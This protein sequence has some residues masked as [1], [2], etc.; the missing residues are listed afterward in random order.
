MMIE[1]DHIIGVVLAGGQSSRMGD[2]DKAALPFGDQ[3]MVLHAMQRLARQLDVISI[4]TNSKILAD[5]V[6]PAP[7]FADEIQDFSG[8]LAGIAAAM[9]FARAHAKTHIVTVATDTP[10]F[11]DNLVSRLCQS[12][13]SMDDIVLA[14][15]NGFRHPVFGLWPAHHAKDLTSWLQ[16]SDT[17]KVM[18]WVKTKPNREVQFDL[19]PDGFD[20]FFNVNTPQELLTAKRR[21]ETE[22]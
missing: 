7:V 16:T 4:N 3:P 17:M 21:L 18:A 5:M 12:S 22:K 9:N 14:G 8:P 20:P 13:E 6:Y 15:S 19:L 10:F 2:Q 1:P 11:P